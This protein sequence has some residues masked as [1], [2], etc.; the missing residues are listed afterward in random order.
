MGAVWDF[1]LAAA[2]EKS[3]EKRSINIYYHKRQQAASSIIL[4]PVTAASA[5][6]SLKRKTISQCLLYRRART[7]ERALRFSLGLRCPL[8]VLNLCATTKNKNKKNRSL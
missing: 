3:P 1:Y 8:P 5:A 7:V 2:E 4:I 6:A